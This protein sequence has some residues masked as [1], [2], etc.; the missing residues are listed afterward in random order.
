MRILSIAFLLSV[1]FSACKKSDTERVPDQFRNLRKIVY[2]TVGSS[3]VDSSLFFYDNDNRLIKREEYDHSSTSS[4]MTLT[5]IARDASGMITNW[6]Y[7][8]NSSQGTVYYDPST[9][10]YKSSVVISTSLPDSS[11]YF[12]LGEK[13]NLVETY[14]KLPGNPS[15]VLVSKD[16]FEYDANGN[17]LSRKYFMLSPAGVW[18]LNISQS[19][20]YDDK[21]NPLPLSNESIVLSHAD[22]ANLEGKNNILA[23]QSTTGYS[24]TVTYNYSVNGKPENG[25]S[26]SNSGEVT[27]LSFFYY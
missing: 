2:T 18:T 14:I 20:T 8:W 4:S 11:V 9:L 6:S 27:N 17:I 26:T 1:A 16:T 15:Y 7:D 25:I 5:T 19:S 24:Y 23:S 10:K 12:Y 22:L 13:I 3:S 21:I